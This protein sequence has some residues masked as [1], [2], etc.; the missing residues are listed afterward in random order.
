MVLLGRLRSPEQGAGV[1][2]FLRGDRIG[3]GQ[4]IGRCGGERTA[5]KKALRLVTTGLSE[6][7]CLCR[8]LHAFGSNGEVEDIFLNAVIVF[9]MAAALGSVSISLTND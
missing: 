2:F 5:K 7:P 3:I 8:C 6:D 4:R 1:W 9:T